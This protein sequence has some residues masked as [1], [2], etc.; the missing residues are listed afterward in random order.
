MEEAAQVARV[1][2]EAMEYGLL[3]EWTAYFVGGL[4]R[5]EQPLEAA[6]NAAIEWDF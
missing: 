4:L 6:N 1:A 5:G 2:E 3:V